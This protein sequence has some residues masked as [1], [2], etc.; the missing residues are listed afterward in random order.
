MTTAARGDRQVVGDRSGKKLIIEHARRPQRQYGVDGRVVGDRSGKSLIVEESAIAA[1]RSS[2][3]TTLD[4]HGS[5][6]A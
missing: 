4:D 3:S 1:A 2:S 5:S 6:A